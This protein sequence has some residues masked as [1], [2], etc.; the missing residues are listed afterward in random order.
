[1]TVPNAYDQVL[2]PESSYDQTH[3]NRLA[4]LGRLLGLSPAPVEHCR[5]LELGCASGGNIIP[6]AYQMPNSQFVGVDYSKRQIEIGQAALDVLGMSNIQLL[7][8]NFLDIDEHFGQFDY[9]IAHGIYS[10][11]PAPVRDKILAICHRNLAP[12][13]VAYISYNTYPGWHMLGMASDMMRYRTRNITAPAE[14]ATEARSL[15]QLLASVKRKDESEAPLNQF[16]NT[17][18]T[19][20]QGLSEFYNLRE[21]SV[22]LHDELEEENHPVYFHQFVEHAAQHGLQYLSEI[23]F[24]VVLLQNLPKGV[25]TRIAELATDLTEAEQYMDFVRNRTFRQTLLCHRETPIDRRL[26]PVHLRD[27]YISSPAKVDSEEQQAGKERFISFDQLGFMTEHPVISAVFHRLIAAY[28][29]TFSLED[30][31]RQAREQ[32]Y[33]FQI[34]PS[35]L[36]EDM[37]LVAAQLLQCFSVSL[38]LVELHSYRAPFV[39]HVSDCPKMSAVA[40]YQA[41]T[42]ARVTNMLHQR[43]TLDDTCLHLARYLDGSHD[44]KALFEVLM[45]ATVIPQQTTPAEAEKQVRGELERALN[46]MARSALLVS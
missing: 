12:H 13:G 27:L 44:T 7:A 37:G 3:P 1:M 35:S 15:I 43:I 9:I 16:M 5:V 26:T 10:W 6:M 46:W 39:S 45:S 41:Q 22:F 2:Y 17:F 21:D 8:M 11:V 29:Q 33:K 4:T 31:V 25:A 24:P 34:A 14:R 42:N 20:M 36:G 23:E 19:L 18:T 32:V 40:R 30:L 38:S 28:P